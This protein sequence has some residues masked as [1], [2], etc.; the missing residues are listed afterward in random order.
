MAG[1]LIVLEL[2][3]SWKVHPPDLMQLLQFYYY[4]S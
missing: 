3:N 4:L 2:H 1:Q